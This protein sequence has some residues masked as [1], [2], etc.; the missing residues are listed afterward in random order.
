V[1]LTHTG[2]I[3]ECNDVV[4]ACDP[5]TAADILT[6]GQSADPELIQILLKLEY[7]PLPI[8]MQKDGACW[9]PDD[10]N[11]W[12][13]INTIVDG[14]G[15]TFSAWFGPMRPPYGAGQQLPVFKSWG[16]PNVDLA[17]CNYKFEQQT[18]GVMMPT[19]TFVG[20]RDQIA[21]WQGRDGIFFAGGWTQWFDS[22]E[23]ALNSATD[24]AERL[25]GLRAPLA[26]PRTIV[27]APEQ[28]R[29]NLA[30]WLCMVSRYAPPTHAAQIA[31][32][33]ENVLYNG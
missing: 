12:E 15:V 4:L 5:H 31:T 19:T 3:I 6:A 33:L 2:G 22:Q 29:F 23:A 27:L 30:Q 32:A 25:P 17:G 7:A 20:L 10:N 18:H 21:C 8:M 1:V 26:V 16:A 14:A 13:T 24:V 11:Y 28:Q 9:M